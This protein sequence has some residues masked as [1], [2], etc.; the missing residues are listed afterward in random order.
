MTSNEIINKL[1]CELAY[2]NTMNITNDGTYGCAEGLRAIGLM[3][4]LGIFFFIMII[5]IVGN[6]K[7][8][9]RIEEK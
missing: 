9:R 6:V 4:F 3:G 7:K 1:S 2:G 5:L 8:K